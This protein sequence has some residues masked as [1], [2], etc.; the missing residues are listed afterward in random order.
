MVLFGMDDVAALGTA[1]IDGGLAGIGFV[2]D[3]DVVTGNVGTADRA[4]AESWGLLCG[5]GCVSVV[6]RGEGGER[7]T[8]AST[9]GL[10]TR[11]LQPGSTGVYKNNSQPGWKWKCRASACFCRYRYTRCPT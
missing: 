10:L 2:L 11:P 9:E 6:S 5:H 8:V 1:S 4:G 3:Q 7:V